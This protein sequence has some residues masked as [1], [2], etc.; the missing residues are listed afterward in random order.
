MFSIKD[1]LGSL[2]KKGAFHV[3]LGSFATKFVSFF[4]S[5]FLVRLL[6]K[7]EYGI[8]SYY[9]N[10]FGYFVILAGLGLSAGALRYIVLAPSVSEKFECY[11]HAQIKGSI[12]NAALII[13]ALCFVY[14]YPHPSGFKNYEDVGA[15]IILCIPFIFLCNVCFA[16]YR[17][18]LDNKH[19]ALFSFLTAFLLIVSR[20][21]GAAW[22]GLYGSVYLRLAIEIL[23]AVFC[24]ITVRKILFP[25]VRPTQIDEEFK[26]QYDKYSFQVMLTDGL[27]AIFMLNDIFLLG[28]LTGDESL[29]A[30]YRVAF[31]IPAN[32]SII[33]TSIGIFVAPYFTKYDNE[34]DYVWVRKNIKKVTFISLLLMAGACILC[35]ILA[36][37]LILLLYGKQYVGIVPL[38]QVLLIASFFNNGIRQ[39]LANI[40]SAAGKQVANLI[41]A[42]AGMA[43][44]IV[45]DLLLIPSYG[46]FGLA[47]SS[48]F[49]YLFMS[50]CLI[51]TVY[52]NYFKIKN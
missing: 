44:Q 11:K 36:K 30:D 43:L 21:V 46:G 8:L 23:C 12:I 15:I 3:V 6:T 47:W 1:W 16:A 27:W 2:K 18:R 20:V 51:I 10:I 4:G 45:L 14:F 33:A 5:I 35:T 22:N 17:G 26:K 34:G 19:Y 25:A 40:L 13:L 37:P 24:I 28:Q 50:I 52:K 29:I 7:Q 38:M 49:V 39:I 9:E 41:V 48:T 31:V 32:L 42:G